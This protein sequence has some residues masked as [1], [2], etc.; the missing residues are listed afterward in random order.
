LHESRDII[1]RGLLARL[2]G[3]NATHRFGKTTNAPGV[4]GNSTGKNVEPNIILIVTMI[5]P[6]IIES[7]RICI[8]PNGQYHEH[9][10]V[11]ER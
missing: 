8:G 4:S 10:Y 6:V 5:A 3:H 9:V 1:I 7:W 2:L 11:Q